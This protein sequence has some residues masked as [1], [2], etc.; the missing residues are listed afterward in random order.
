MVST[1]AQVCEFKYLLNDS[2][3]LFVT[4][5]LDSAMLRKPEVTIKILSL[6]Q[7]NITVFVTNVL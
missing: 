7:A 6:V 5:Y 3:E 1:S 2:F 4:E